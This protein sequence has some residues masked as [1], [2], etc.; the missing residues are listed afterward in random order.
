MYRDGSDWLH[1]QGKG[2]PVLCWFMTFFYFQD[3]VLM[4]G[5]G[6]SSDLSAVLQSLFCNPV[7]PPEATDMPRY[8]MINVIICC[9]MY[10]LYV[11]LLFIHEFIVMF[12]SCCACA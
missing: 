1:L 5:E 9:Q 2:F 11:S 7:K 6:A 3:G 12:L 8:A 4:Y 10:E